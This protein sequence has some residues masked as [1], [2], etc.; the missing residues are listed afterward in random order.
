M[1]LLSIEDPRDNLQKANR[2]ELIDYAKA[3]GIDVPQDAPAIYT[4][5]VLRARGLTNIRVPDRPLG[6]YVGRG[7]SMVD[8]PQI[9]G[10]AEITEV[11]A[12]DHMILQYQQEKQSE[13]DYV[14]MPMNQLRA[15]CKAKGIKMQR[16]DNINTLREKLT[17][18][19]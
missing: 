17:A 9:S 14:N 6:L 19:G 12:D 10:N 3:N 4:M 18:N 8:E 5:K 7:D 2:W 11:S 15:A 13:T 1:Q 16:T